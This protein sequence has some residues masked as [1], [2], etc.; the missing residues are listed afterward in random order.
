MDRGEAVLEAI[1]ASLP[2]W[3]LVVAALVTR[4]GDVWVLI[5]AGLVASWLLAWRGGVSDPGR[6]RLEDDAAGST[7]PSASR[8]ELGEGPWILGVVVGGLALVI[9]LKYTFALPRPTA[10]AAVPD[11]LPSVLVSFYVS[12]V[13]ID[14]YAFP[15]GHAVGATVTYGL[16]ATALGLGTLRSRLAVAAVVAGAVGLSRLVLVVHY[17]AD[18]AAGF[19]IGLAYLVVVRS[20]LERVPTDRTT[21]S[22]AVALGLAVIAL[23]AS[24]L[25]VRSIQYVA[26]ATGGLG[27]W[28]VGRPAPESGG[29]D[30]GWVGLSGVGLVGI[31]VFGGRLDVVASA[32]LVGSL[33][34]VPAVVFRRR[35]RRTHGD[36]PPR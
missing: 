16:L 3:L 18:V 36:R 23:V 1:Q 19:A 26:L 32:A 10:V 34:V 27:G 31:G 35:S 14:G 21:A 28:L 11:A 12:S 29:V 20:V 9:V 8:S 5:T 7:T 4:L 25:S 15:S 17:P 30:R 6:S 22:F 2:D 33:A 13:T 24:G